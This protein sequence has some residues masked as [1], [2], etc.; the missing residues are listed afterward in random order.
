[1]HSSRRRNAPLI[2]GER[3]NVLGSKK[4]RDLIKEERYEEAAEIARAQVKR[5]AH[6][7]DVSTQQTDRDEVAD[8]RRLLERMVRMV[9][10]P[11]MIDS[12]NERAIEAALILCQGKA[13]INFH[14]PRGWREALRQRGAAR[15]TVRRRAGGRLHRR[16]GSGDSRRAEARGRAAQPRSAHQRVEVQVLL[17]MPYLRVSRSWLR[18]ATP[19]FCSARIA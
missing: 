13:V 19:S 16:E 17:G 5:G 15:E 4:F 18:S 3:T 14:Q 10:A 9:R 11:L 8:L 7:I 6:V 1:M 2:V 12:T